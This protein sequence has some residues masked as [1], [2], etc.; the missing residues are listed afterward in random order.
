MS[1]PPKV[2][3]VNRDLVPSHCA[4]GRLGL[5]E[6]VWLL[7]VCALGEDWG[8]LAP[9]SLSLVSFPSCHGVSSSSP[10]SCHYDVLSCHR[11]KATGLSKQ[12]WDLWNGEHFRYSVSVIES[13]QTQ[14]DRTHSVSPFVT[15]Y[16]RGK[17]STS[18]MSLSPAHG[19][20][21]QSG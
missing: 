14:H 17:C 6:G 11:P 18:L 3:I 21:E 20:R 4:F 10:L 1:P 12:D 8:T 7:G 2:H 13:W 19:G 15:E 5:M 16:S 9:S